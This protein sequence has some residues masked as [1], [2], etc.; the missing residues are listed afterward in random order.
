MSGRIKFIQQRKKLKSNQ[1]FTT[2]M[3]KKNAFFFDL[4]T[5]LNFI[6]WLV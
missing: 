2:R 6:Y 4:L 1:K 3:E 5:E